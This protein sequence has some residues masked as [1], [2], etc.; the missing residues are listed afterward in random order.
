MQRPDGL[1]DSFWDAEKNELKTADLIT[2]YND[3][4]KFKTETEG[5]FATRPEA[6]D[7]YA[8]PEVKDLGL[9]EGVDFTFDDKSP[10]FTAAREAA[11]NAGMSQAEFSEKL[12][13]PYVQEQLAAYTKAEETYQ[14]EMKALG[15][16]A[17]AR[18]ESVNSFLK[19]NVSAEQAEAL[20]GTA[21]TAKAVEAIEALITKANG[22]TFKAADKSNVANLPNEAELKAKMSD[23]KYWRDRDPAVVKEVEDGFKKLYP[24]QISATGA[25]VARA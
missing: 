2:G 7:K 23:P 8:L 20:M 3:L 6:A 19:A 11:F 17:Q 9:P 10:L 1:P 14:T 13:K 21:V 24:S 22:T 4:S 16:N 5:R 15:E 12:I 25:R 18:I